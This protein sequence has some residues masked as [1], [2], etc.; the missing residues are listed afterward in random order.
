MITDGLF[1]LQLLQKK[2]GNNFGF[3]SCT[4]CRNETLNREFFKDYVR[5]NNNLTIKKFKKPSEHSTI[6]T[7]FVL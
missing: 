6:L 2:K 1:V 4:R 7:E 5:N 3:C